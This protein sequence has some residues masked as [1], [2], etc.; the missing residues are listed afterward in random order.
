MP[1]RLAVPVPAPAHAPSGSDR[2]RTRPIGAPAAV[3]RPAGGGGRRRQHCGQL[4]HLLGTGV[5]RARG[6]GSRGHRRT[7]RPRGPS[8]RWTPW[9]RCWTRRRASSAWTLQ[10]RHRR[11]VAGRAEPDRHCG[12]LSTARGGGGRGRGGRCVDVADLRAVTGGVAADAGG[13]P[14]TRSCRRHITGPRR[15]RRRPTPRPAAVTGRAGDAPL[16]P[17]DRGRRADPFDLPDGAAVEEETGGRIDRSVG[18]HPGRWSRDDGRHGRY[19]DVRRIA[20]PLDRLNARLLLCAS[21]PRSTR[22]AGSRRAGPAITGRGN[23]RRRVRPWETQGIPTKAPRASW[24]SSAVR[25][26]SAAAEGPPGLL[27]GPTGSEVSI[28][29]IVRAV[30]DAG[31][32][33]RGE[34][35]EELS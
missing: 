26:S 24:P 17:C 13:R 23:V 3:P 20:R 29:D 5:R 28:A 16:G 7:R 27:A 33:A 12:G 1:F 6:R 4:R 18:H 15:S 22:R 34:A 31:R 30:E 14:T 8:L 25:G 21:P 32:R 10:L 2:A 19:V 11:R 35:P 9:P